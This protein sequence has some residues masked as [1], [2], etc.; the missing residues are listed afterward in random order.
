MNHH[1]IDFVS[2][3]I[4]VT[5]E[6]KQALLSLNIIK[7]CPKGT[8]LLKEGQIT[9]KGFFVLKGCIR[10]YFNIDGE[11]KTTAFYTEMEGLK[12]NCASDGK[13]SEYY[14]DCLEDSVISSSTPELEME[15][16]KQFPRFEIVCKM[17]SEE[18]I[19]KQNIEINNFKI[20]NPEQR[21]LKLQE[22]RP[23]LL[24]RVPQQQIAS[25]LGITPQSLSRIRARL[26]A[27]ALPSN[28]S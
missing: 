24:Q 21:Y 26:K 18:H 12:P 20:L 14:I 22:N 3:Y 27:K 2:K 1:F 11:E 17:V 7:Y 4:E 5:K 13:P 10:T 6:E 9:D 16:N 25:F 23:D 19:Q 28:V 8:M 15:F